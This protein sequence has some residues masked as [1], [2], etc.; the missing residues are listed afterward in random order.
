MRD[1]SVLGPPSLD[2]AP[3][4]ERLA[5]STVE[6]ALSQHDL[7]NMLTPAL[8]SADI[9]LRN[10]NPVVTRQAEIVIKAINRIVDRVG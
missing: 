10:A 7:R 4:R 3:L 8:L 2:A 5:E 6:T 9:L 1:S